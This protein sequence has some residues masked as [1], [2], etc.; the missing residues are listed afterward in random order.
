M[1]LDEFIS[2]TLKAIIKGVKDSQQFA[3]D[4][5]A[6]VNPIRFQSKETEFVFFNKEEG[7]RQL[8]KINFDIAVTVSNQSESGI[9]GGITV[10]AANLGGKKMDTEMNQTI[11]RIKF[12]VDVALPHVK[13]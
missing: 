2:G 5:G 7:V 10:F 8:S 9:G 11:S 4:N 12:D 1:N 6:R 3:T 13:P